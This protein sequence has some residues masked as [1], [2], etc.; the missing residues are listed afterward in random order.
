MRMLLIAGTVAH[1]DGGNLFPAAADG[2]DGAT[3]KRS[4]P[5]LRHV[6]EHA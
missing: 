1:L 5:P 4:F 2:K 6:I 3:K